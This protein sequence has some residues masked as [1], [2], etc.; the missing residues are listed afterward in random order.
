MHPPPTAIADHNSC[1]GPGMN[2]SSTSP[3][4]TAP[5]EG[6]VTPTSITVPE[7]TVEIVSDSGEGAQKCGQLARSVSILTISAL[8]PLP[9]PTAPTAQKRNRRQG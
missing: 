3:T 8:P 6:A 1:D 9:P 5:A 2:T 4:E 7:H